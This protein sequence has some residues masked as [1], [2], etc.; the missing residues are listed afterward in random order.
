MQSSVSGR[1]K[2]TRE[3][4][5][6]LEVPRFSS[7]GLGFGADELPTPPKLA[8]CHQVVCELHAV[9]NK[10]TVNCSGRSGV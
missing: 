7:L 10:N 4:S 3:L 6:G 5:G 8:E 9:R 1:W 2:V